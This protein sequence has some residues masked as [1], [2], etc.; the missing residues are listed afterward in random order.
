MLR[1]AEAEGG[2]RLSGW[3]QSEQWVSI[4]VP[5]SPKH[6]APD[7]RTPQFPALPKG[8]RELS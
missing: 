6:S 7:L 3:E 2:E 8:H 4:R 5:P 1:L